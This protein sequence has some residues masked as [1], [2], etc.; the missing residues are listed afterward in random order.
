[1][2]HEVLPPLSECILEVI[3]NKKMQI[4]KFNLTYSYVVI[5]V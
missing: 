2:F 1:V 3:W 4:K 5:G